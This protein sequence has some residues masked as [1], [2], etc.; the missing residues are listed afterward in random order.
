MSTGKY[1]PYPQV[2][3]CTKLHRHYAVNTC[4]QQYI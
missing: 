4:W 3:V 1:F 2:N